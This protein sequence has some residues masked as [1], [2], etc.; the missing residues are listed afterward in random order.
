[1]VLFPILLDGAG[2]SVNKHV[3]CDRSYT[4][5]Y[6]SNIV[7]LALSCTIFEIFSVEEYCDHESN[8]VRGH[9]CCE[10]MH[11]LYIGEIYNVCRKCDSRNLEYL[12][13]L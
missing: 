13:Q 5:F 1:M 12:V 9:L 8:L 4:T 6:H 2:S 11:D 7:C 10:F 3:S